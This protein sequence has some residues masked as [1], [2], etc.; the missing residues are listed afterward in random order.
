MQ[1]LLHKMKSKNFVLLDVRP[2]HEFAAG[3][4]PNAINVPIDGLAGRIKGFSKSKQYIAY[5]RG[6]FCVFA[7]DAV[8]L[9]TQ[10]GFKA[11]RLEEGYPDWKL[12]F[13]SET[14]S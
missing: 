10:K 4:I 9:L 8:R 12:Q 14:I 1:E 3:H 13:E 5:C 6:P 11:R 7:D 2:E